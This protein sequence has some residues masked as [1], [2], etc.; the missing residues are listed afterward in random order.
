MPLMLLLLAATLLPPSDAPPAGDEWTLLGS[1]RVSFA[2]EKD[3]IAVT[4]AAGRF[5]AI[6]FEVERGDLELY[7]VRVVF[8]NG[9][10]FSPDTRLEFRQGSQSRAIDLPGE[11]RAISRIEFWYRS[12]VRRGHATLR[13]FGRTAGDGDAG[14][15]GDA[16]AGVDVRGWE[17]IGARQV[18]FRAERDV[19]SGAGD[20]RFRALLLVVQGGDLE[21]FDVTVRFGNG[22]TWSPATRLAFAEGSRSRVLDLPGEARAIRTVSF[23][24]RSTVRG[25]TRATV[26]V[27]GR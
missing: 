23:R 25:G 19:I 14:G 12:R 13:V 9:E 7:N 5:T 26:S 18:S 20:G 1:R 4:A 15:G 21:M 11:A 8:A 10:A 24:Y 6:R 2:A 3:V 27:Y 17:R 22:E 16:G